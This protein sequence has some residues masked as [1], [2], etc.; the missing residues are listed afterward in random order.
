MTQS[1][2][3][4]RWFHPPPA[5]T[6]AFSSERRPGVVLRVSQTWTGRRPSTKRAVSVA[7]P[8]RWFRK[9]RAVR[10]A[11]RIECSGPSTVP[12]VWP[13]RRPGRRRR[14]ASVTVTAGSSWAKASVAHRGAGQHPVGA[15]H[16]GGGGGDGRVERARR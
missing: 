16:E 3:L 10:S 1:D 12:T 6:A 14:R 5:R 4:P 7:T 8:E 13:R 11:V 15:G 9:F 2:R